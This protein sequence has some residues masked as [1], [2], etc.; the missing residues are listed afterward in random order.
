MDWLT[1]AGLPVVFHPQVKRVGQVVRAICLMDH[2]I[3]QTN[4]NVS[5]QIIIPAN[6]A[7]RKNGSHGKGGGKGL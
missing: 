5:C 2:P 1:P 7:G 6:Q 3:P 4:D